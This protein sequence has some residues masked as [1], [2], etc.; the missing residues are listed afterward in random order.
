MN[1]PFL[2]LKDVTAL[3]GAEI[4]EAVTRVVNNGWY[5]QGKENEQ[6][7]KHYSNYEMDI[8]FSDGSYRIIRKEKELFQY[9]NGIL[10]FKDKKGNKSYMEIQMIFNN[11]IK[12][13][14]I[15]KVHFNIFIIK[16]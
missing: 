1:I 10:E 7:E 4:N 6:F 12:D 3:H 13:K 2:S 16:I 8:K 14:F 5:L 9:P 15:Y 11:F